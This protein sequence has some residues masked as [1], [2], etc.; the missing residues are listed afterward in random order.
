MGGTPAVTTP[1][2]RNETTDITI[3]MHSPSTPIIHP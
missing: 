3:A 1:C 2:W